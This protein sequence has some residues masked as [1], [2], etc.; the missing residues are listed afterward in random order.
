MWI[1]LTLALAGSDGG[2][3]AA[4]PAF[5]VQAA[6]LTA[7]QKPWFRQTSKPFGSTF[8]I[9]PDA[10][11]VQKPEGRVEMP[12][13][14]VMNCTLRVIEADPKFDPKIARPAPR[15]LDPKIVRP[16]PCK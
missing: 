12:G 5:H 14:A 11:P 1:L 3:Q 2:F 7:E 10:W 4:P 6:T 9:G 16:S 15:D 8:R 13:P